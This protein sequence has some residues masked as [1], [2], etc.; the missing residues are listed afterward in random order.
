MLLE[1]SRSFNQIKLNYGTGD[2]SNAYNHHNDATAPA[3]SGYF[4]NQH[5]QR[6]GSTSGQAIAMQ[7]SAA[8][9]PAVMGIPQSSEFKIA[10]RKSSHNKPKQRYDVDPINMSQIIP[11]YTQNGQY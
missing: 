6:R 7:G 10:S 9:A 11:N 3:G 5:N 4:P 1:R 8:G 2:G